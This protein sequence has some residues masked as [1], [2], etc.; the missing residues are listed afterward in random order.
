MIYFLKCT[1]YF[2]STAPSKPWCC[3]P[4]ASQVEFFRLKASS[5]FPPQTS[6]I[7]MAKQLHFGQRTFLQKLAISCKLYFWLF[8]ASLRA[9]ICSLYLQK[10]YVVMMYPS[11]SFL[12]VALPL[13]FLGVFLCSVLWAFRVE[14][15]SSGC[16][17]VDTCSF[18]AVS[19]FSWTFE[20]KVYSL[21]GVHLCLYP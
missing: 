10:T 21:L 6:L 2:S 8:Y 11:R 12:L 13:R 20:I 1:S 3:Q 5:L 17:Y 4:H 9:Y 16:T 15:S 18:V 19:G 14:A 7:I